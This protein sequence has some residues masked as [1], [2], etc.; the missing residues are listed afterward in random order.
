[1]RTDGQTDRNITKVIF[2]FR[3]FA[4]VPKNHCRKSTRKDSGKGGK[5]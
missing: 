3:N 4:N 2:A 5:K 1:M